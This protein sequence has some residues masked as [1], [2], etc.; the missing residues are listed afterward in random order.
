M[1][2][3]NTDIQKWKPQTQEET[4]V[5]S[6]LDELKKELKVDTLDTS[7]DAFFEKKEIKLMLTRKKLD[8]LTAEFLWM[9]DDLSKLER[10]K[11]IIE[12]K[13]EA[14]SEAWKE[15]WKL[16][17]EVD[18]LPKTPAGLTQAFK[19]IESRDISDSPSERQAV[20]K[21]I[22]DIY[23]YWNHFHVKNEWGIFSKDLKVLD[24]N[25]AEQKEYS[26][27][28]KK[29]LSEDDFRMDLAIRS[30]IWRKW[31]NMAARVKG[32]ID[33]YNSKRKPEHRIDLDAELP[34]VETQIANSS[35][36]ELDKSMLFDY[37]RN[38]AKYAKIDSEVTK[39]KAEW[40]KKLDT[41]RAIAE[42]RWVKLSREDMAEAMR[43]PLD[44]VAR[45]MSS[46]NWFSAISILALTVWAIFGSPKWKWLWILWVIWWYGIAEAFWWIDK[47]A[48]SI[49]SGYT[50]K[51]MSA[52]WD[53]AWA[54]LDAAWAALAWSWKKIAEYTKK[55]LSFTVEQKERLEKWYKYSNFE[56]TSDI[57][58]GVQKRSDL[59]DADFH[60]LYA[61]TS[62]DDIKSLWLNR[63]DSKVI[64]DEERR[65]LTT[66]MEDLHKKWV[67]RYGSAKKFEEATAWKSVAEVIYAVTKIGSETPETKPENKGKKSKK[68]EKPKKKQESAKE[69]PGAST[70]VW[71]E[72]AV[73]IP[74]I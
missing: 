42:K 32:I 10:L 62:A 1:A 68:S 60:N 66:D 26:E 64:T 44:F 16:K 19:L 72:A 47:F 31:E 20:I 50:W 30:S 29:Y 46:M 24:S 15:I 61:K 55:W 65:T 70:Q 74:E 11:K 9:K 48:K 53:A 33:D 6:S 2:D 51:A 5:I 56:V 3:K 25:W 37:V 43:N 71:Y 7:K 13:E 41:A 57:S 14:K 59:I 54:T 67:E 18:W 73:E 63:K 38:K 17:T 45:T 27:I 49:E 40:D 23:I 52:T 8:S 21:A 58:N 35:L 39:H 4:V 28:L 69:K 12:G 22:L 34:I 36:E